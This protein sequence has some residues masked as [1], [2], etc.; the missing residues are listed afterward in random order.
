MA[1]KVAIVGAAQTKYEA[2]KLSTDF[3]TVICNHYMLRLLY[4][5]AMQLYFP[6]NCLN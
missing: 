4:R 6:A 3:G 2:S 5:E 1:G